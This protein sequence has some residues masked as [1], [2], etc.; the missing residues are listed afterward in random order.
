MTFVKGQSGNPG[1]RPKS[2]L[3]TEALVKELAKRAAKGG[4]TQAQAAAVTLVTQMLAG[5]VA[6]ARLVL[7]Y[8]EGL[9][10]QPVEHDGEVRLVRVIER[11]RGPSD[12]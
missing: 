1:G 4:P 9:P 11:D 6:A 10:A 8:V 7:S 2:K 5:D 12:P 3:V